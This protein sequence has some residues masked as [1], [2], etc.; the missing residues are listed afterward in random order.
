MRRNSSPWWQQDFPMP[1]EIVSTPC[2]RIWGLD[3]LGCSGGHDQLREGWIS[4]LL[5]LEHCHYKYMLK[6]TSNCCCQ[7]K[8]RTSSS[9]QCWHLPCGSNRWTL[10]ILQLSSGKSESKRSSLL[11][12]LGCK[13]SK[14]PQC[15]RASKRSSGEAEDQ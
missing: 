5:G 10:V 11:E 7:W 12:H 13:A 15:W 14:E 1:T 6:V 4:L 2:F 9:F 3:S 8:M